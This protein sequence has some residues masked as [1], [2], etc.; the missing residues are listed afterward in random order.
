MSRVPSV[1]GEC[2]CA[3]VVLKHVPSLLYTLFSFQN[4][5]VLRDF[6]QVPR[7]WWCCQDAKSQWEAGIHSGCDSQVHLNRVTV[8]PENLRVQVNGFEFRF[9]L[10]NWL[11]IVSKA[12]KSFEP[13]LFSYK[14]GSQSPLDDYYAQMRQRKHVLC[15]FWYKVH[16]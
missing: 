4:T 13:H 7:P 14:I 11:G 6:C 10:C 9:R 16:T 15:N 3:W 5:P 12:L 2:I 8:G 1:F